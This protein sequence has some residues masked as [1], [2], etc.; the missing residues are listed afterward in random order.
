VNGPIYEHNLFGKRIVGWKRKWI[1]LKII[2]SDIAD[3]MIQ[4]HHYSGKATSNRFLSMGAY[5]ED[6]RLNGVIQLGYGIRPHM[7]HTWGK[8][9]SHENSVEFDR[10]WLSDDLP[11]FSETITIS[12]LCRFLKHRYPEIEYILSYADGSTGRNGT[13]YRAAN[14]KYIG[15]IKADFYILPSGERVHPVTM[16]H[17]HG[18]RAWSLMQ[19][20]YPGIKKADGKQH[21]FMYHM[22][23]RHG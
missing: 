22:E 20:L 23:G 8:D 10:M 6:N 18:S 3:S 15:S 14:F 16:W 13:I 12:C 1:A 11:K 2:A 17:R 4:E 21:R 9:V 19:S 5:S 7:K